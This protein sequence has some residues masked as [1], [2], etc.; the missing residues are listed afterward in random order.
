MDT[1][2]IFTEHLLD[3]SCLCLKLAAD[4]TVKNSPTQLDFNEIKMLQREAKTILVESSANASLIHLELPWLTERKARAA[5]PYALED[6][7]AQ[8]VEDLHF[9]F[10]KT[11]YQN[12]RYLITVMAKQR[13]QYLMQQMDTYSITFE[14][15]TIDWFALDADQL[16]ISNAN[17]LINKEDFKGALSGSLALNYLKQHSQERPLTFQDTQLALEIETEKRDELSYTWIAS[18]LLKSKPLNLCQ[19]DMQHGSTSDWIKKG[20]KLAAALC[21]IWLLSI[22]LVN[23]LT[24]HSLNKKTALIDKQIEVIYRHFFPDAKQVI[25]PKFRIS[26]LLSANPEESQ[27]RFWFLINEFA[28][29]MKESSISLE[30]LRYQ[31]QT[32]SATVVSPDFIH[33]EKFENNLKKAQLKVNQTQASTQDQ[34]VIATLELT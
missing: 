32:L 16:C 29:T 23:A 19:G 10:D 27:T 28:K 25:S 5:I 22:L 21:S 13:V 24:L 9:A 3:T 7:V 17:L 6:K 20:Y 12:N 18:K 1:C 33:L 8:P 14:M 34:Q 4:G 2:F 26:Q 30:Q 11:H 15:I 31:N